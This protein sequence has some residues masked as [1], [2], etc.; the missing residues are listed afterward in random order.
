MLDVNFL[1]VAVAAATFFFGGIWYAPGVFGRRWHAEAGVLAPKEPP[2]PGARPGKHPR[3][4]FGFAYVFSFLGAWALAWLLGPDPTVAAGL[5]TGA[6]V[7]LGVAATSFGVN[8][9]FA[10]HSWGLWAIDGGYH[11]VQFT[12]FGLVLGLFG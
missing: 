5:R 1:A 9:Q 11:A 6:L 12:L 2:R 3:E 4:V 10:A 8:Y 7:G